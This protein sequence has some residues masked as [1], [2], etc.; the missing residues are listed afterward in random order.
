VTA[1]GKDWSAAT[2]QAA[3]P[4]LVSASLAPAAV[5]RLS[6]PSA[7]DK[8]STSAGDDRSRQLYDAPAARLAGGPA[9]ATCAAGLAGGP[10]TPVAVD[11]AK[12]EGQ[13]AAVL[14]LPTP[15]DPASVDVYVV[16]PTCPT[17]EFL[18]FARVPRS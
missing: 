5:G 13:P 11:L 3:A 14:L 15:D 9:L 6:A 8:D 2:L 10:V 12:Y 17:G 4:G 7:A 18:Y 16:K 1:T